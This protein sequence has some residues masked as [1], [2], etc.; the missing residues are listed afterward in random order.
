MQI[1]FMTATLDYT[2]VVVFTEITIPKVTSED[3]PEKI[4]LI[5]G[6]LRNTWEHYFTPHVLTKMRAMGEAFNSCH[7]V[8]AVKTQI[9]HVIY[10][11]FRHT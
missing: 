2:P 3:E 11:L 1:V 7:E 8:M 10:V 5:I 4:H 9:Y 6:H